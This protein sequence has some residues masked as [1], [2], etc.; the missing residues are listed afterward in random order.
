[1]YRFFYDE[2]TNGDICFLVISPAPYPDR[3]EEKGDVVALWKGDSLI[4]V[5]FLHASQYLPLKGNGMIPLPNEEFLRA[6][7]EK[8]AKASLPALSAPEN[9]GY[10]VGKVLSLEEHP[11]DEK[12]KIV[13]LD[14]GDGLT[15]ETISRYP[16]LA[17]GFQVVAALPGCIRFDGTLFEGQPSRGIGNGADLCSAY[18]LRLGDERS[19]AFDASAY[20]IGADFFASR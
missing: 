13:H 9:S 11:L 5:N 7:N 1:M 19:L 20:P 18:D 16:N 2:P 12:A 3:V 17:V 4:G 8:L 6:A 14:F 10:R 15:V